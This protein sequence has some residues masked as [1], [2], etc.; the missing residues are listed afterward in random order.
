MSAM[1]QMLLR[2]SLVAI[3]AMSGVGGCGSRGSV[4]TPAQ[5]D[6]P[7]TEPPASLN[8]TPAPLRDTDAR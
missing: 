4:Q 7:P 3:M 1:R 5:F 2:C 8:N 6:P